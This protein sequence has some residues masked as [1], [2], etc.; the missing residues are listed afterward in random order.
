M[1]VKNNQ[2]DDPSEDLSLESPEG[3]PPQMNRRW[4]GFYTSDHCL[5]F[6]CGINT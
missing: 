4:Q 1:S 6:P 2:M 5:E 3:H